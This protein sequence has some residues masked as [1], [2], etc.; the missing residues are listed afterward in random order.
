MAWDLKKYLRQADAKSLADM[1]NS[2]NRQLL[3]QIGCKASNSIKPEHFE[4]LLK[5]N[6][7]P[8]APDIY[9]IISE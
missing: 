6:S 1:S 2:D 7:L 3:Y 9:F 5:L 8:D 4:R